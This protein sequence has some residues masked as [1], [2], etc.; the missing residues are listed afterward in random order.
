[1]III[2]KPTLALALLAGA[3]SAQVTFIGVGYTVPTVTLFA[4]GQVFTLFV[5]GLNIRFPSPVFAPSAPLPAALGGISV[6]FQQGT[7]TYFF[8]IFSVKQTQTCTTG[9]T[10]ECFATAI[11]AQVPFE[12]NYTTANSPT[13][14][15]SVNGVD[16]RSLAAAVVGSNLHLLNSCDSIF[17]STAPTSSLGIPI[18][19]PLVTHANGTLASV[20]NEGVTSVQVSS[21][22]TIVLYST[23]LGTTNPAVATGKV[24]PIPAPQADFSL[25]SV[26][27][28]IS[29]NAGGSFPWLSANCN[30]V[31]CPP[32]A[33]LPGQPAASAWLVPGQVGLY[34]INITLP[35]YSAADLPTLCTLAEGSGPAALGIYSNVT[36]SIFEGGLLASLPL[37]IQPASGSQ[38]RSGHK[39]SLPLQIRLIP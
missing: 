35:N 31:S 37:C 7:S 2:L 5:S 14:V 28:L 20:Y 22:E 15:I 13:L 17:A 4:P 12:V 32:V 29:P 33:P 36:I 27:F 10:D 24:T 25:S 9:T 38:L 23:G 8:A 3:A 19:L 30:S 6:R 16:S 34:Q 21:G 26:S 11:T 1:M 18:C 39:S